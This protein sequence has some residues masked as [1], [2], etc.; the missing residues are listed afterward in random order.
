MS[1]FIWCTSDWSCLGFSLMCQREGHEVLVGYENDEIADEPPEKQEAFDLVGSGLVDKMP[2][3]DLFKE[4]SKYRGAYWLFDMNK[5]WEYADKLRKDGFKAWGASELT[6]KLELDREFGV[7]I[8]KK[9]GFDIPEY[10]MFQ[11]VDEAIQFLEANDDKAYVCK[12]NESDAHLT[13]VPQSEN[14]ESS[15]RELR[16][17]L[18]SM[19]DGKEFI[20]QEKIR[21]VEVNCACF[22]YKGRPYFAWVDLESK[23]KNSGDT[24][25]MVG[26]AF[27]VGFIVEMDAPIVKE[28]IGKMFPYYE[29]ERYTGIGDCNVLLSDNQVYFIEWCARL[30]YNADPM[31]FNSLL[32]SP[33]GDTLA[34]MI[35]GKT[36][37]FYDRFRKGFGS[38]IRMYLDHEKMGLPLY[39]SKEVT[40]LWYDFEA[41]QDETCEDPEFDFRLAGF[42]QDVGII[43]GHGWTMK[44]AGKSALDN[45]LKVN[46]PICAHRNDLDETDYPSSPI[47]R[48][49]ALCALGLI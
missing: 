6:Q 25:E 47:K 2:M 49:E 41:Y 48:Y 23:R 24:G 43:C 22:F 10:Q 14:A 26:C 13:Y 18:R 34:A 32:I 36:D 30:G 17:Y 16:A 4:R 27:D 46:F 29:K 15:N 31:L 21:G 9:A 11:N 35:D 28:T 42:G 40:K 5:L 12:P 33:F 1:K 44:D 7:Q 39:V 45:A 37:K 3:A 20:L 19:D 38:S 8:A